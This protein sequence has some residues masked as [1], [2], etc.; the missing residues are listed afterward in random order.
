[1]RSQPSYGCPPPVP[2][3]RAGRGPK[4][5]AESRAEASQSCRRFPN[6][7]NLGRAARRRSAWSLPGGSPWPSVWHRAWAEARARE[8]RQGRGATPGAVRGARVGAGTLRAPA[9]AE[10]AS[11]GRAR[12]G[13]AWSEGGGDE[14]RSRRDQ[15]SWTAR[16]SRG[17]KRAPVRLRRALEGQ[18]KRVAGAMA[19]WLKGIDRR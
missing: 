3:L 13:R 19:L 7:L 6:Q 14:L 17:A 10:L 9:A 18:G 15:L 2:K 8:P 12:G 16:G 11:Q 5:L 1:M 4:G